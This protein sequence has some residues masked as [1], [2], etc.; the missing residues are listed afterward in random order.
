[1][2]AIEEGLESLSNDM[3]KLGMAQQEKLDLV[4][5]NLNDL[6]LRMGSLTTNASP[7]KPAQ[8]SPSS[9][10]IENGVDWD[11]YCGS[12][13]V[14]KMRY[15]VDKSVMEDVD[16]MAIKPSMK[17]FLPKGIKGERGVAHAT[18]TFANGA[19]RVVH[20]CTEVVS[21]DGGEMAFCVG[22]SL[23]AKQTIHNEYMGDGKF[24]KTFCR[25]QGEAEQ[26]AVM[27]NR[28]L[29]GGKE[30]QLHFLPCFLYTVRDPRYGN[31]GLVDILVEQELEGKFTKWNNN[32]GG[33]AKGMHP[34]MSQMKDST[35]LGLGAINEDDEEEEGSGDEEREVA[36][37]EHVPQCFSHFT[38]AV[39]DGHKL[40]CD[41]QGVWNV[42]DGFLLT[43]PVIHH[44]SNTKRNGATDKGSAGMTNFFETHKCNPLCRRLGLKPGLWSPDAPTPPK[45]SSLPQR[46]PPKAYTPD[47]THPTGNPTPKKAHT[48][49][50]ASA[51]PTRTLSLNSDWDV[52]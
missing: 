41:I 32:A 19:E 48:P 43:D 26:L 28:R 39:T 15:N 51:T 20:Q 29:A 44:H 49:Q 42:E 25:T 21:Y 38:N 9:S 33:V 46:P 52:V 17:T 8:P 23:V 40:V 22:P 47:A 11:L 45:A 4:Q 1:M 6:R 36:E 30:W 7:E 13:C 2:A 24:H 16:F 12:K 5:K 35:V 3:A 34:H 31:Y 18:W 37:S 50:K 14:S 27:F 10:Y